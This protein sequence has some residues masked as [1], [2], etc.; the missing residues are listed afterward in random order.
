MD[1]GTTN[2]RAILF[3]FNGNIKA[4]AQFEYARY[5]PYAGWVEQEPIEILDSQYR[6]MTSVIAQSGIS[7]KRIAAIGISNQRETAVVWDKSTGK[8]IYRAI[9]WQ[10]RRTA[11]LCERLISDGISDYVME[12]TGLLIDAYFSATKIKW[13][14]DHVPGSQS[15]AKS[16][17][18]LFGTIDSWLIYNLTGGMHLTDYTNAARTMLFDINALEWDETLSRTLKIPLCMLPQVKP[19]CYRYGTVQRGIRGLEELAGIPIAGVAGDQHAALFG[20]ACFEAGQAKNTY[21]TGCFLMMN[22][23]ER[24]IRSKSKLLTTIAWGL[25]EG[26]AEY[27]LEG[28]AFNTGSVIQWLRDELKMISTADEINALADKVPNTGGVYLVPAFTGLGAPYWDM[29]ARGTMVG[30]TR[31]TTREHLARAVLEGI[32]LQVTDLIRAMENDT[33]ITLTELRVDGGASASD[34]LMQMQADFL[35]TRIH[36]SCNA[37]TTAMGAAYFAGLTMGIF[38]NQQDLIKNW[39]SDRA[40]ECRMDPF[41]RDRKYEQW[42]RAV[43]RSRDWEIH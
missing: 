37:E 42:R 26:K 24:S 40:F 38:R 8:P 2:S 43:E 11:E 18:L 41:T 15:R 27:A 21:G 31:G 1:Q 29:Y 16:G 34:I 19:S 17:E 30:L 12:K 39:K 36:R 6:A 13:I 25:R 4:A 10:C 32:A 3:D 33:G 9:V 28:S 7:A 5:Y 35:G 23:G 22:T 14:L 20:Q